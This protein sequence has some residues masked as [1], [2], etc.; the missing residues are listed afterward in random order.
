MVNISGLGSIAKVIIAM[1]EGV[2]PANLHYKTPN[3]MIP[4]LRD[5]RLQVV[6]TNTPFS[7]GYVGISSF[8]FGG[9]NA[10]VVLKSYDEDKPE[11]ISDI[12]DN[13]LVREKPHLVT[14]AARTK[15][16]MWNLSQN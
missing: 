14:M 15:E 11:K 4:G 6:D 1:Q 7:G 9:T 16:V 2:L 5:G 10:H 12:S 13:G 3:Q 8:G